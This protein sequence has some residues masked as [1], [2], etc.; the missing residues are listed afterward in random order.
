MERAYIS[1][2]GTVAGVLFGYLGYRRGQRDELRRQKMNT[3]KRA[4]FGNR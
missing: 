4:E 2:F 1:I 3:R